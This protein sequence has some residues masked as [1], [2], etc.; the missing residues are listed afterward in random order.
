[1]KGAVTIKVRGFKQGRIPPANSSVV[2]CKVG[3]VVDQYGKVEI[4]QLL[5]EASHV[6]F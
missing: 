6:G 5:V 1:M 3:V 2:P 4:V